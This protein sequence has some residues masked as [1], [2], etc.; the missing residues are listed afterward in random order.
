MF[1][2]LIDHVR[3]KKGLDKEKEDLIASKN[4]IKRV[5]VTFR[6]ITIKNT[7]VKAFQTSSFQ[8]CQLNCSNKREY[9]VRKFKGSVMKAEEPPQPV[10]IKWANMNYTGKNKCLRRTISWAISLF[11]FFI[12]IGI[13]VWLSLK[14]SDTET[15][16]LDCPAE[17]GTI[18]TQ[19]VID[20]FLLGG[21]ESKGYC[22]CTE[23]FTN[24]INQTFS[25][26]GEDKKICFDIY[27]EILRQV[28]YVF[29]IAL[30]L[31]I[32]SMLIDKLLKTLSAFE[33]YTD[34]NAKFSSRILKGF[35]LKYGNSGLIIF[36]INLKINLFGDISFGQYDDLTPNWYA[37]IGY[38]VIFT[39]LLKL[40][41]LLGWTIYR[42]FVPW[43]KRSCDRSCSGDISK[44]KK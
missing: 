5:F 20:D 4:Q 30:M 17:S 37:T 9:D 29:L 43:L 24:R 34:L 31:T 8:R 1:K 23:D 7:F 15:K 35:V 14:V 26:N 3:I 27:E 21:P 28:G 13:T 41:T 25:V 18:S 40:F 32:S 22:Y 11:L 42:A 10:N 38:S 44:T 12:F 16:N 33:K 6:T 2:Y 19:D 39:Y 36:V